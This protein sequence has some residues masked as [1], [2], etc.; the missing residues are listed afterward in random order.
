MQSA[1]H[2]CIFIAYKEVGKKPKP[3]ANHVECSFESPPG[4]DQYC[5]VKSNELITGPC[6]DEQHFGYDTG[7][8]CIII[9]L[10]KVSLG[11]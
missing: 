4:E 9:K 3:N 5:Q 8:P 6:T 2:I 10:N 1:H 11:F 7:K